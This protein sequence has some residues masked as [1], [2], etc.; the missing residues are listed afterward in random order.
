MY[1]VD[2]TASS[3]QKALSERFDQI[4]SLYQTADTELAFKKCQS[5]VLREYVEEKEQFIK[6]EG[7][8]VESATKEFELLNGA[9]PLDTFV[10]DIV[11]EFLGISYDKN[12]PEMSMTFVIQGAING[13]LSSGNEK[14]KALAQRILID[15]YVAVEC[16]LTVKGAENERKVV[17]QAEKEGME[18][19]KAEATYLSVNEEI[20]SLSHSLRVDAIDRTLKN[21]TE[22][23]AIASAPLFAA[24]L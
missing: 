1:S 21:L 18:R 9:N 2:A 5:M 15:A 24:K 6:N 14:A 8:S 7:G 17:D 3:E 11:F 10:S 4:K 16:N 22:L 20:Y 23:V 19:E 13:A 12:I